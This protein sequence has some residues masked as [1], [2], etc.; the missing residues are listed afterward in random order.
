MQVRQLQSRDHGVPIYRTPV[1]IGIVT[2]RGKRVQ[3]I[4]LEEEQEEFVFPSSERPLL[5]RFDEGNF[6]LKEWSYEKEVDELL[7]QAQNDDVIGREWAVRELGGQFSGSAQDPAVV[8]TLTELA[9]ADP[10]WAV[11]VA[12]L[13]GLG[14]ADRSGVQP[15]ALPTVFQEAALDVN[16]NV[17]RTAIRL[18]GAMGDPALNPFFQERFRQDDSYRVQAEALTAIGQ[19]G[20]RGQLPFLR[21]ALEIP[22]HQDVIRRAAEGA[23]EA[24]SRRR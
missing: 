5:V 1:R 19:S 24:L 14:S 23:I 16:S 17:R 9:S 11:R 12:A 7:Y 10:F 8:N 6:L 18:L 13:E 15:R 3:E 4:W 21:E 22:S 2:E 20:D